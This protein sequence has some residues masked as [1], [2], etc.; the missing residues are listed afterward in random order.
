LLSLTQ[1][2]VSRTL[3]QL[4]LR[5]GFA[6]SLPSRQ[7]ADLVATHQ[8]DLGIVEL[9]MTKAGLDVHSLPPAPIVAVVPSSHALS[10]AG[11]EIAS[12]SFSMPPIQGDGSFTVKSLKA[13]CQSQ[14][15]ALIS[16]GVA[17]PA[18]ASEFVQ[19]LRGAMAAA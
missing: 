1:P 15:G 4:E 6:R 9:P 16:S 17:P 18:S 19:M 10:A 14:Y 13:H 12:E 11:A 8:F 7:I 3:V 2:A 5:L